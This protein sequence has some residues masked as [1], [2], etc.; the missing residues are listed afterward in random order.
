MIKNISIKGFFSFAPDSPAISMNSGTNLLLGINGSGKS[1]F[2]KAIR[3][4]YEGIAGEGLEKLFNRWDGFQSILN[5][6][7]PDMDTVQITYVF[8]KTFLNSIKKEIYFITDV[9]Y[10]VILQ[11]KGR[12]D[13]YTISEELHFEYEK[14]SIFSYSRVGDTENYSTIQGVEKRVLTQEGYKRELRLNGMLQ[15][16]TNV[17]FSMDIYFL[18]ILLFLE[19]IKLYQNF[20]V[21]EKGIIRQP[22][23]HY[24]SQQLMNNGENLTNLLN[25]LS[26][27]YSKAYDKII[28]KL[29]AV[30]PNFKELVFSQIGNKIVLYLKEKHLERALPIWHFSDGTLNY[31]LLM[32]IFYN[33]NRG[34]IICLD[35]PEN[36]LHPDMILNIAEGIKYAAQ[37]GTQVIVA[38]HS[39]LLLNQFELDDVLIF[40]KNA[41]N[42]TLVKRKTD[43]DFPEWN[44]DYLMG[45]KWLNGNIGGVRW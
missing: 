42:S 14:N 37:T 10:E 9:T 41:D 36:G 33:P 2:I 38:T 21:S 1:N 27:D 13:N 19:S 16:H 25:L 12:N 44:D 11:S 3:L 28:E 24:T 20:D 18:N 29:R 7:N 45:Q 5:V 23:L 31:L 15:R 34:K 35:E 6:N 32:A 22:S 43:A 17:S 4:L 30:N 39:P 26:V 8:D 40:E